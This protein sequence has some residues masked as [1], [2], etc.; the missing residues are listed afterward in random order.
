MSEKE[1]LKQNLE[2]VAEIRI[3][4]EQDAAT[5]RALLKS[6]SSRFSVHLYTVYL[7]E[8]ERQLQN[9]LKVEAKLKEQ[10]MILDPTQIT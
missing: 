2:E 9:V 10:M 6:K 7:E 1:R 3:K 4:L 5:I 8:Q